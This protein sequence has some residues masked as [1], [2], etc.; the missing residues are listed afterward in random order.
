M[1]VHLPAANIPIHSPS[2]A[3]D[4]VD[5]HLESFVTHAL[6][7]VAAPEVLQLPVD[8]LEQTGR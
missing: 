3:V 1:L 2:F 6:L 4:A 7:A 8:V 5:D